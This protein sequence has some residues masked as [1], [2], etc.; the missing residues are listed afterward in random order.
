MGR[1]RIYLDYAAATPLD[2][3]VAKAMRPFFGAAFGNPSSVHAEGR[4][5]RAAVETAR[6]DVA[7]ALHARPSEI[8][9]TSGAT[10]SVNLAIR[11]IVDAAPAD[12]RHIVAVETEHKAVLRALEHAGYDVTFVPVDEEGVV[13]ADAVM[14][15]VRPDTALV[16]IM[17]VNNEIGTIAPIAEVG[18]RIAALR[19]DG[20]RAYPKFHTD[21]AQAA[22][23]LPLNVATLHVDAMSLSGAKIYGP[24]GS[25][26]LYVKEGTPLAPL[27]V[28]GAQESGRRA[29]TEN[30]PAIVGFAKA[31]AIAQ[32]E[33][34]A[35]TAKL[36]PLRD[37]LLDGILAAI[38]G[39]VVNGSR[40]ERIAGNVN[41]SLPSVDGEAVIMYLDERGIAASTASSCTSSASMSHVIRA[42]GRSEQEVEASIRFTL[43]RGTTAAH[44]KAA[45]KE[46]PR[47]VS[48]LRIS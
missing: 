3:R 38:P 18:K 16:N 41:V 45:L 6:R 25:G 2:P 1:S 21:A 43:G 20:R 17:Y 12:C 47:I 34:D 30:V 23:Y 9:W 35:L 14:A 39:A 24:K 10:E 42:L 48:L 37:M 8:V 28:G 19:R 22:A 26:V 46:L 33:A 7:D 44:V 13:S 27:L 40:T 31:L 29:G 4:A 5:A 36:A 32:R 11:G 15:A